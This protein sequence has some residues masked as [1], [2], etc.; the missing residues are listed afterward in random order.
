[1]IALPLESYQRSLLGLG[2][3][4]RERKK[5]KIDVRVVTSR[6]IGWEETD[7]MSSTCEPQP[8]GFNASSTMISG[9]P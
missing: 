9:G 1:M 8:N 4:E 5:K 3:I 2:E 7:L 6:K